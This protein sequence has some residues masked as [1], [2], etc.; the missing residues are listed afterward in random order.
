MVISKL[1]VEVKEESAIA[2]NRMG[3]LEKERNAEMTRLS[4]G[5]AASSGPL[6]AN[7]PT[8]SISAHHGRFGL[9]VPRHIRKSGHQLSRSARAAAAHFIP[10]LLFTACIY[11]RR[12]YGA[13]NTETD[14]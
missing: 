7:R 9:G 3:A 12:P 11:T 10:S 8:I 6:G 2:S 4:A 14:Q 5:V 1:S 13:H